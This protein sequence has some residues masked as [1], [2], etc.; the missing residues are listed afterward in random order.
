MSTEAVADV[1]LNEWRLQILHEAV[2]DAPGRSRI[3]IQVIPSAFWCGAYY[4]ERYR[5]RQ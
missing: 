2:G 1:C 5:W 4:A 3:V